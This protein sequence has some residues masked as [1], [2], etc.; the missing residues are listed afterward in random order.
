MVWFSIWVLY[1]LILA[2]TYSRLCYLL[3]STTYYKVSIKIYHNSHKECFKKIYYDDLLGN[4]NYNAHPIALYAALVFDTLKVDG[5]NTSRFSYT[6][7]NISGDF[8]V[9]YKVSEEVV[10]AFDTLTTLELAELKTDFIDLM[11]VNEVIAS[12]TGIL[13]QE[14][15]L[16]LYE[17]TFRMIFEF[18]NNTEVAVLNSETI[19]GVYGGSCGSR[20][21]VHTGCG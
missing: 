19:V 8:V 3:C 18:E 21:A 9:S 14:T 5:E 4:I 6:H 15:E 10:P 20:S 16:Q 13:L 17:P 2:F 1:I 11:T 12:I 7:Q